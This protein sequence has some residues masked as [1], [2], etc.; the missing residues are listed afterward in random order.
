M[1][2]Q[3]RLHRIGGLNCPVGMIDVPVGEI[4]LRESRVTSPSGTNEVATQ[5]T[6]AHCYTQRMT[7]KIDEARMFGREVE[8]SVMA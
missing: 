1:D 8:H 5:I 6:L 7:H 4:P 2:G 3:G